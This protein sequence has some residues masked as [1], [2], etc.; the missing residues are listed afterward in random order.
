MMFLTLHVFWTQIGPY[1]QAGGDAPH[2]AV[3][4]RIPGYQAA[5]VAGAHELTAPAPQRQSTYCLLQTRG[6]KGR[7]QHKQHTFC[8]VATM[9]H[10]S[11]RLRKAPNKHPPD[12]DQ[13]PAC[14]INPP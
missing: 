4:S 13:K 6:G 9:F 12:P 14:V 1:L 2:A 10:H 8:S 11:I 7:L 3:P 5:I